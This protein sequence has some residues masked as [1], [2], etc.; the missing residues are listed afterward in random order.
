MAAS[1]EARARESV[2]DVSAYVNASVYMSV[3]MNRN[4]QLNVCSMRNAYLNE[5]VHMNSKHFS[6]RQESKEP[7]N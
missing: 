4:I 6:H 2:M 5:C 7:A 3:I 1:S